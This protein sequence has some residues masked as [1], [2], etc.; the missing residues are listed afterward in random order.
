M[1][2]EP[3]A[4]ADTGAPVPA[5]PTALSDRSFVATWLLAWLLGP[6]GLDRFYLG[7]S[8][9]GL[10]KLLTLGGLG[11]WWLIDL[12]LTLA[13][14]Q[15]DK[16]GRMLPGYDESRRFAWLVTAAGIALCIVVAVLSPTLPPP[17]DVAPATPWL[18]VQ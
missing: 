3:P 8:G 9:T 10:L 12:A 14:V 17:V 2:A 13:G 1:V 18:Q 6:L 4:A 7:K 5:Q 16:Q 15:H 11:V